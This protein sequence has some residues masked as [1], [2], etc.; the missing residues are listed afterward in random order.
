[1]TIKMLIADVRSKEGSSLLMNNPA[2][3]ES[4]D[5]EGIKAYLDAEEKRSRKNIQDN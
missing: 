4:G 5:D 3:M 1:M 2:S